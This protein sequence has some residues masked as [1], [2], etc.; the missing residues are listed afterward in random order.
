MMFQETI[1]LI[2]V[3]NFV[4]DIFENLSP[5][6]NKHRGPS[7]SPNG[8]PR[9]IESLEGDKIQQP[10]SPLWSI[11]LSLLKCSDH[12]RA[13]TPSFLTLI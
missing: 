5:G 13:S 9:H 12:Q 10:P 3:S 2:N 1:P 6:L 8:K 4:S 7:G 11:Y